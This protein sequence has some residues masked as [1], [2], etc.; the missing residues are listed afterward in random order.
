MDRKQFAIY[1]ALVCAIM[2]AVV[3]YGVSK[4]NAL[5]PV[6]AFSI[7]I[8][9]IVL[10]KRGVKEVMEDER[11]HRISE[12]ASR[13]I[14]QVFVMGAALAGTILIALNKHI[15]VGYTLAFS[16]CALLVLYLVLY[17]YYNKKAF[18]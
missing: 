14:Y 3:G 13:R 18:E 10:G 1:A 6:I 9:L 15:E 12:K 4:G 16:A 7:G 11:T 5:L 2:G 8:V 17:S